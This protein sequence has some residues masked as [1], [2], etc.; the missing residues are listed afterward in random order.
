MNNGAPFEEVEELYNDICQLDVMSNLDID[1]AKRENPA[2]NVKELKLLK[3]K[4]EERDEQDRY[5]RP[6]FF[7]Y[8]D[9]DKGYYDKERKTYKYY[10]TTM[11]YLERVINRDK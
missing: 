3:Q 1:N 7:M 8:L 6:K 11:D 2:D 9:K 5:I 10:D 4:Y